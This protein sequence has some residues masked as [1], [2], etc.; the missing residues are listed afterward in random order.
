MENCSGS[1]WTGNSV[2]DHEARY[3]EYVQDAV[4]VA[5][6]R[7]MTAEVEDRHIEASNTCHQLRSRVVEHVGEK[8]IQQSHVRMGNRE[9]E[10]EVEGSDDQIDELRG[11]RKPRIDK[12]SIHQ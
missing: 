6:K 12:R 5:L 10:G 9:V 1:S 3:I 11:T 4:K 8:V 7:M 2:A